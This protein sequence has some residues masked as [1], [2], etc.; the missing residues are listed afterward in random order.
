MPSTVNAMSVTRN[1]GWSVLS[2]TG[3]F[4]LKFVTVPILARILTPEEFGTVA[5]AL[6][7]VQFLAMIGGAGLASALIIQREEDME[8]IHS[9][10]WANL[11][12]ALL[13]ALGLF[14]FADP[15]ASLLGAPEAGYLLRIMS[16]LIPL[17]LGGDVAYSLLARRMNFSK[18]AVWTMLSETVGAL[19]AVGAALFG[20]GVWSLLA[21]LF[22]SA[23]IRLAGLYAVSG[24]VPRLVFSVRRV[25]TLSRF[26]FGMM[27]SEIANFITFQSPMV[28]ISRYLGLSDAGAYSAANRFSSIPNQIVLSAVMGVLF[29]AFSHMGEDRERRSQ[30]LMLSTQVTTVLLA[31]MMFGLWALAEPAMLVLFGRQWAA[32]W[33]VLGLLALS[34]GL[35]TPCSTYVPYLKGIGQG[36]VLFWWAVI[37]AIVT[38]AAVAYGAIGGSLVEAMIALCVVN[39]ATLVAY[40]WVVFRADRLPFFRNLLVSIRPMIAASAMAV[41]V[42]L[43]LDFYGAIVPNAV[44]QVVIGTAVGGLIYLVLMLLM[45]R[46]LLLKLYG[47]IRRRN[48]SPTAPAAAE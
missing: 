34:K 27:G 22:V 35:L 41:A 21:Q 30:A 25:L 32:A 15:L 14:V 19:V 8:L 40:S 13:M 11:A 26:S 23:F 33:P 45:E 3:T 7:V 43:L 47:M 9:A 18:D 17:Q 12:V 6:T 48:V 44:V 5:V 16:V 24:Y 20:F 2:K 36:T 1:V 29:P 28:V 31:P 4:G 10:F 42:R 38:T 39:L 46:P 37:R